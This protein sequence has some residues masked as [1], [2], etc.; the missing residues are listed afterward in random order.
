[1]IF[2]SLIFSTLSYGYGLANLE[3]YCAELVAVIM[4][5]TF[6]FFFLS[7]ADDTEYGYHSASSSSAEHHAAQLGPSVQQQQQQNYLQGQNQ[8]QVSETLRVRAF[9]HNYFS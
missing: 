9:K 1:M 5:I 4:N 7:T 3:E 6:F 2:L 8:S